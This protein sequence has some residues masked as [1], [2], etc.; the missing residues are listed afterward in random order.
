MGPWRYP[1]ETT[2]SAPMSPCCLDSEVFFERSWL[3]AWRDVDAVR[4]LED[5]ARAIQ[6][7]ARDRPLSVLLSRH[8]PAS[9]LRSLSR[10]ARQR[11]A[12]AGAGRRPLWRNDPLAMIRNRRARCTAVDLRA[13]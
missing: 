11:F 3:A 8:D 5:F 12:A 4:T 6:V 13:K 7:A 9:F 10:R 1:M 2:P